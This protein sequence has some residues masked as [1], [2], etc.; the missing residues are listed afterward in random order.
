MVNPGDSGADGAGDD[1]LLTAYLDGELRAEER[2]RVEARLAAE[3]ELKARLDFLKRGGR[4]F[5]PAYE[6][7]AE[8]APVDRLQ[9]MLA[10]LAAKHAEA[11]GV[12]A[13]VRARR[14]LAI[15]AVVAALVV[16][17]A[18]G[19]W[20]PQLLAPAPA[21]PGW[22][23][24]VAEYQS[25]TTPDTLAAVVSDPAAMSEQLSV[26]GDKLSVDLTPARLTLPE[27]A[28][29]RAQ[30]YDFRGKPLAE[31]A[32]LSPADG[33]VAFC[34]IKNGQPDAPPAFEQRGAYNIVFWQARG[35][36]YMVIGRAA[37]TSLEAYAAALSARFS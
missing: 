18:A 22:R 11:G 28:L 25:L 13:T 24:V 26:L 27:A 14:R 34:I 31:V 19:H 29:K 6:A 10:D 12:R 7:L 16:G 5:A 37:R 17:S 32:Y 3:P 2:A 33:A 21:Q 20:L 23:Q 15:A 1:A 8:A 36:G 35:V 30:L 9:A 4:A